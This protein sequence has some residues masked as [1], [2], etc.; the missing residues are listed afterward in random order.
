M[1]IEKDIP[2]TDHRGAEPKYPW[3]EMDV[4]DSF[5]AEVHPST[6]RPSARQYGQRHGK[7]FR[8]RK[9][10]AGSRAWRVE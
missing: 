4:G 7:V 8:V 6:L 3:P 5:F 2:I 10:G 9:E 1:Q